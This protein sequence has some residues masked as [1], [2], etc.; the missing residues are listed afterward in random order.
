MDAMIHNLNRSRYLIN[1]KVK[2]VEFLSANYAQKLP[3]NDTE[4]M[5]VDFE[6]GASSFL[7]ITWAANLEIFDPMANEREHIGINHM[8][9]DQGWF[10]TL[11]EDEDQPVI[12]AKKN[13][14]MKEWKINPL[15]MTPYDDFVDRIEKGIPQN[16]SI[17][18]ALEDMRIM[19]MAK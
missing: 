10:V 4:T 15:P 7:F 19:D 14:D 18:M 1:Q 6:N 11:H 5:R 16:H 2:N 9:T 12:R 3:C 17:E 13:K 8:I